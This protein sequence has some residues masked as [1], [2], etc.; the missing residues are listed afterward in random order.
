MSCR[1]RSFHWQSSLHRESLTSQLTR[2][3]LAEQLVERLTFDLIEMSEPYR[4]SQ[5]TTVT[6][7]QEGPQ[8]LVSVTMCCIERVTGT[9]RFLLRSQAW[10]LLPVPVT[11]NLFA[12]RQTPFRR[13]QLLGRVFYEFRRFSPR[14]EFSCS[15]WLAG[16]KSLSVGAKAG[17]ERQSCLLQCRRLEQSQHRTSYEPSKPLKKRLMDII[18]V[19]PGRRGEHHEHHWRPAGPGRP[20][21]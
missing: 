17:T 4:N 21:S 5:L 6:I 7:G 20:A 15:C 2:S 9:R 13:S 1:A 14:P 12:L 11:D 10:F 16:R 8:D 19:R 18:D 3:W